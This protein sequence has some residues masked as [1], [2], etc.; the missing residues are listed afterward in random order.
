MQLA[1]DGVNAS[2]GRQLR[3]LNT[4]LEGIDLERPGPFIPVQIPQVIPN[5]LHNLG[6]R[7]ASRRLPFLNAA[8]SCGWPILGGRQVDIEIALAVDNANV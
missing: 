8:A 1:V 2:Q 3:L 4:R 7:A 6:G 5:F